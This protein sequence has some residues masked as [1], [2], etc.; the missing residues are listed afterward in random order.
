M[1]GPAMPPVT[2]HRRRTGSALSDCTVRH[3]RRHR[4][5]PGSEPGRA[6]PASAAPARRV[7]IRSDRAPI[8]GPQPGQAGH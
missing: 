6:G 8:G 2:N 4:A 5:G 1:I 3:C 7:P